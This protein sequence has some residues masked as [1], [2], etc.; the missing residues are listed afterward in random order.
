MLHG[1]HRFS[2]ALYGWLALLLVGILGIVIAVAEV[3]TTTAKPPI[4]AGN[5]KANCVSLAF[6]NGVLSQSLINQTA[7]V[8]G[9]T[10]NCLTVFN[11]PMPTWAGWDNPWMFRITQDGW[12]KWVTASAG[13]QVI[14]GEALVPQSVTSSG[15]PLAW[16]SACAT[17]DYNQYATTLAKNLVSYG[18]GGVVIRL[19]AEANG[20]WETDYVGTTS[21]EMSDWAKCYDHEVTAMRAVP[22]AHFLFVWGPNICTGNVPLSKWYPGNGY[23]NII[24]ADAYDG[25]CNTLKTVAQ[26]GWNAYSTD[27]SSSGEKGDANFPSLA[28]IEAFAT[29]HGKAMS[30]PEWGLSTKDDDAPYVAEIASLFHSHEYAFESYFD[31]N[32]NGIAMLGSS[33][34]KSTAEYKKVFG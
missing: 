34:P 20:P 8:T 16:E 26:E 7:S 15:N 5:S 31:D 6:P 29:A 17:G 21:T 12:G 23:V 28:N 33:I 9:I 10:Y 11:E 2:R 24:G 30:I 22:G 13:H 19:G 1:R 4:T 27:S 18:A 14:L 32:D 25:D 3:G